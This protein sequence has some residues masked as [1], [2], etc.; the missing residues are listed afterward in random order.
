MISKIVKIV[1]MGSALSV[2]S[3]CAIKAAEKEKDSNVPVVEHKFVFEKH[4]KEIYYNLLSKNPALKKLPLSIFNKAYQG[5][6]NVQSQ[7]L[8]N[9]PILTI[10]DFT[11]SSNEKR[12]WVIDFS[13]NKVLFNTLVSHGRNTGEEYAVSFSNKMSSYQSSLGFYLTD[14]TYQGGNGYSLKLKGLEPNVNDKAMDRAIVMHGADYCSE[15]F[16]AQHGRLGR[17]YGCPAVP[18]EYN[19]AIINTIKQQT[20]LYIH[21]DN[22]QYMA[23]SKWLNSLPNEQLAMNFKQK[24]KSKQ[25]LAEQSKA[26]TLIHQTL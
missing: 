26:D 1:L 24:L 16:I 11:Q 21:S 20:V 2:V 6:I 17:S 13:Q 4:S 22:Q 19:A 14:V 9:S 23:S 18:R 3:Y 5:F 10:C 7:H 25:Y 15:A 8:V 12:L